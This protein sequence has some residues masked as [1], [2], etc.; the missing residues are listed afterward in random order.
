M[1]K[2]SLRDCI[3]QATMQ[4]SRELVAFSCSECFVRWVKPQRGTYESPFTL[5]HSVREVWIAELPLEHA[6]DVWGP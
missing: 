2:I 3:V 4:G 5:I 6:T 1:R